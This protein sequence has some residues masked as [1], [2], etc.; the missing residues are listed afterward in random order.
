MGEK[1]FTV[2][3]VCAK[4]KLKHMQSRKNNFFMVWQNKILIIA[5]G[6]CG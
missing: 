3:V 4:Q 2:N 5:P 1:L 6:K